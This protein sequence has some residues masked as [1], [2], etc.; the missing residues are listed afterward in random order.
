MNY[1]ATLTSMTAPAAMAARAPMTRPAATDAKPA[2]SQRPRTPTMAAAIAA[3]VAML[4]CWAGNV[5]YGRLYTSGSGFGYLLGVL[6]GSM[7][8]VLLLYALRKQLRFMREWGQLKHWFR[9]HM[10]AGVL[11]P[12]L[13]LFHSTFRVGSIN[14]GVA[15]SCML[16]VVASGLAGRFLY[17][18]IHHGLYGSHATL[19]ELQQILARDREMLAPLLHRLPDVKQEIERFAALVSGQPAGWRQRSAHFLSLGFKRALA[20]RRVRRAIAVR[21]ASVS[22]QRGSL[23]ADITDLTA[24]RQTIDDALQAAQRTAQFATYERLFSLW[25]VVHVPFLVLLVITAVV[26]V[27]A[28]HVY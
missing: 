23:P 3:N 28:V 6:G 7:I 24:L 10:I 2:P 13:V 22:G 19:H 16:L 18:K 25:R 21:A 8:L 11:G 4:L 14:A 17:R 12:L 26:H 27:V 1:E 15:L 9:F 20:G 5:R